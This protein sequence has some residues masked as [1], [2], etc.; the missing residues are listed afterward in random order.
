MII[1]EK[2]KKGSN[3][4]NYDLLGKTYEQTELLSNLNATKIKQPPGMQKSHQQQQISRQKSA[5]KML[6][7]LK[8]IKSENP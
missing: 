3:L 2:T 1:E 7:T 8:Q 4:P 5:K 6:H